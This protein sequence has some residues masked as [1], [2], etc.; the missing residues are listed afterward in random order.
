MPLL[1]VATFSLALLQS[2]GERIAAAEQARLEACLTRIETDPAEAYEDG[3]AWLYQG[4]R[5]GARQCTA[6]ALIA[7]GHPAEGAERLTNLANASDA[8]TLAERAAFLSQAGNAWIQASNPDAALEAFSGALKIAPD[9]PELLL[10]RASAQLLL[11]NYDEAIADLDS[12]L[13]YKPGLGEAHQMRGEAWLAKGE[14]DK[15]MTDVLAAMEADPENV[16][17]LV[18]RGR[19]REAQRL[20]D[21]AGG[22]VERLE[23]N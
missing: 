2:T 17:T 19:V 12:A 1:A 10:D 23:N 11:A 22:P 5:P 4:N 15:A 3:L 8:G 21:E 7:L 14:P 9:A 6:L 13:L 20:Q 16:D 18:L